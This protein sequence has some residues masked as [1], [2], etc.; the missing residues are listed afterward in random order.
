MPRIPGAGRVFRFPWMTR[1]QIAEDVDAEL[2]AHLELRAQELI[3]AGF[4]SA[5]AREEARRRFGDLDF[6]RR[7]CRDVDTQREQEKRR[8]TL[9]DELRQDLTYAFRSLRAAPAFTAVAL[10]TLAL[11]IGANTA[12]FSVVRGVLLRP[13]PFPDADRVVR[14]WQASRVNNLPRETMSEP[15]FRD[16]RA[17]SRSFQSMGAYRY[18]GRSGIDLTGG[19][20]PQAGGCAP[21]RLEAAFVSDGFFETLRRPAFI[22]RTLRPEENVR[23]NDRVVVLGHGLW[24]RRYGA[25]REI[26]GRAITLDG[27]PHTV[28]GVMPPDFT[29]PGDRVDV[30]LPL[31][32]VAE[33][34][35]PRRRDNRFLD[36]VG[37]LGSGA[38]PERAH[39]DLAAIVGRLAEQHPEDKLYPDVTLLPIR[40]AL[41][42]EVR[43]PLLVLLGAVSFVVLIACVNIAS[44]LL[45]R[46]TVRQRELAVRA[47]LG[48]GRGRIARQL[49]TESLTLALLGGTL[50]LGL[51]YVGV[52]GLPALGASELPLASSIRIDPVVLAFTFGIAVAAGLLFGLLPAIRAA[53]PDLQ[54]TL[55][56]GARGTVG[57]RGQRLRGALVAAEV[58]LAVVLVAGAGLATKSF[59]RLLD[60]NPGFRPENVLVVTISIPNATEYD[61][62]PDYLE[63]IFERI[64]AIP[65][66]RGVGAA[67]DLPLRGVGEERRLQVPPPADGSAPP[68]APRINALHVGGDYFRVMGI[69]LR[70]G[71]TFDR[72]DRRDAPLVFV[73]N[74]ALARRYFGG[75][76]VGKNLKFSF[77]EV[78]IIGVVGDVRQRTLTEPAEPMAYVNLLQNM[79]YGLSLVVRTEGDPLRYTPA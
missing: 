11:G 38:T 15:G 49:L 13:L 4:T 45:A 33:E 75:H 27:K 32:R 7:Y 46:A 57:G 22:G 64:R 65:G 74:E 61:K 36:V 52:R 20:P 43:T 24:Q 67:K 29:Y 60:I 17:A 63:T 10:L 16:M 34:A 21:Q 19:C 44:L 71:R 56:A 48:A 26:L 1:R 23:G 6:T 69:P 78:P 39:A 30:W 73:V 2:A 76:A 9:I 58:A 70:E 12:I 50:G 31:S 62:S 66:V 53:S 41:T 37:R 5:D 79:R 68:E 3:D 35:I 77:G 8:M 42:G 59:A 18:S 28:V 55:R 72:T 47:A 51:A 54:G 40:Q 25:D 14:I